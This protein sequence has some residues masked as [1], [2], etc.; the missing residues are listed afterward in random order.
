MLIA[1]KSYPQVDDNTGELIAAADAC[2][3]DR[4]Y[5]PACGQPVELHSGRF[6]KAWVHVDEQTLCA[7][8]QRDPDD[9]EQALRKRIE[10]AEKEIDRQIEIIKYLRG[11]VDCLTTALQNDHAT[12]TST[13]AAEEL[14]VHVNTLLRWEREGDLPITV[15]RTPGGQR[16]FTQSDIDAIRTTM[17]ATGRIDK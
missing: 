15:M 14:D 6:G 3:G 16:R 2:E 12:Y 1:L 17:R 11:E 13:E 5:C 10:W 4:A 7:R 8:L 9:V